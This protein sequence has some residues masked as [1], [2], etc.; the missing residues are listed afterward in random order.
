MNK[1]AAISIRVPDRVKKAAE[2]AATDDNR[3]L[4]SLV[5]K[6]LIDWLKEAGYLK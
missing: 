4:A 6:I 2:K 5:E 1:N 3:P